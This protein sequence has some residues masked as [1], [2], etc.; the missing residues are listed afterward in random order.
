M[1]FRFNLQVKDTSIEDLSRSSVPHGLRVYENEVGP[2]IISVQKFAKGCRF[3]PLM[4]PKSYIPIENAKFPLTIFGTVNLDMDGMQMTTE[5]KDLFKIRHI[6]LDT[7]NEKLCNWMIHVDPAQYLNEQNLIAYEE[8]NEIFFAAIEDLD[9]GDILKVWYSPKYGE[10]MKMPQLFESP[11]PISKN[12]LSHGG[13]NIVSELQWL[14]NYSTYDN[15]APNKTEILLPSIRTIIKPTSYICYEN[16]SYESPLSQYSNISSSTNYMGSAFDYVNGM[17]SSPGPDSINIPSNN[18]L[19]NLDD[20]VSTTSQHTE[21]VNYD[22]EDAEQSLSASNENLTQD[23][24][25]FPNSTQF[26]KKV[27]PCKLCDKKYSTMTNIYRHVRAQHKLFLCS[28]C[29]NMFDSH[30]E[31]KEHIHKC[32]KSDEKK[33]QCI[34]CMQYFSNSW[35]LTRHLKIHVAAGEW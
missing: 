22:D 3:G 14:N 1:N 27:Y 25:S 11:Y 32:P 30:F 34:V 5:F 23:A 16:R 29:M 8:D 17:S 2:H 19:L 4:A 15:Q 35:S 7:R 18:T 21:A 9:V 6:H 12:I 13:G 28:L 24:S 26:E 20:S 31:L 10:C 33:P